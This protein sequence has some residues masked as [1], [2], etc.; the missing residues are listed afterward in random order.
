MYME[1]S[2][3]SDRS[4][5][6]M[7]DPGRF[8][9]S[10]RDDKFGANISYAEHGTARGGTPI[11]GSDYYYYAFNDEWTASPRADMK[12]EQVDSDGNVKGS[13]VLK[14]GTPVRAL[15]TNDWDELFDGLTLIWGR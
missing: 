2:Q 7:T 14:E 6:Y 5:I 3:E 12:L 11:N 8:T 4:D 1:G 13:A 15:R 10:R 9:M